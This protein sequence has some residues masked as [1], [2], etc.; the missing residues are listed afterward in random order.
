MDYVLCEL[1]SDYL[2]LIEARIETTP[3]WAAAFNKTA[4]PKKARKR[5]A[6]SEPLLFAE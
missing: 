1:N 2:P 4:Q 5:K 3:R 6:A